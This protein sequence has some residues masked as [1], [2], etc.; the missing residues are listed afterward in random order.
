MKDLANFGA[1]PSVDMLANKKSTW[2][3]FVKYIQIG[4][5]QW[6]SHIQTAQSELDVIALLSAP[7]FAALWVLLPRE[8]RKLKLPY[9]VR[10][11]G[12]SL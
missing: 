8:G 5:L 2:C 3:I 12:K 10:F 7:L 9:T 4:A 11:K 1:Y 6:Q